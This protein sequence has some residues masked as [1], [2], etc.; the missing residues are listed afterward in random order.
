MDDCEK[1]HSACECRQL[2]FERM[3]RALEWI[4]GKASFQ[5]EDIEILK[6][7]LR[8]IH[9]QSEHTLIWSEK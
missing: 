9:E 3:W 2:Q 5:S 7:N 4:V 8:Q 6:A 1:H